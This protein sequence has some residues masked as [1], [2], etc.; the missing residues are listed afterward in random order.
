ME[1][2]KSVIQL[3]VY[4]FASSGSMIDFAKS[5]KALEVG[6]KMKVFLMYNDRIYY[7]LDETG[8]HSLAEIAS[9]LLVDIFALRGLKN[10]VTTSDTVQYADPNVELRVNATYFK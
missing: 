8:P 9:N 4:M 2:K 10:N 1:E 7:V 6:K 5:P 3:E